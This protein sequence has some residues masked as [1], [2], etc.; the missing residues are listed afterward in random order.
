MG[1]LLVSAPNTSGAKNSAARKNPCPLSIGRP[2]SIDFTLS[3]HTG[4]TARA[5]YADKTIVFMETQAEYTHTLRRG[6]ITQVTVLQNGQVVN[7]WTIALE[8]G[9]DYAKPFPAPEPSTAVLF[10]IGC[11]MA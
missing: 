3:L 1:R 2:F 4:G 10:V 11:V 5:D 7:N 6:G 8:S 9:F